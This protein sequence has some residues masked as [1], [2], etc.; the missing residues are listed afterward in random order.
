MLTDKIQIKLTAGHGGAGHVSYFPGRK[1]KP[2]GG[3]GGDGG[4]IYLLAINDITAL[5]QYSGL[6]ELSAPNGQPGGANQKTGKKGTSIE[7]KIPVGTTIT[8]IKTKQTWELSEIN[9]KILICKGGKSGQGNAELKK[10][11]AQPGL[12]G[13]YKNLIFNLKIIADIGLIGLPNAG[14]TSFLNHIT[15]ANAKTASYAFTTLEPNLGALQEKIIADI[16]GLIE[17]AAQ[18]KGLGHKFLKH[19]EKVNLLIHCISSESNNLK[20]DYQTIRQELKNFNPKLLDK[21]EKILLT[22]TDI[23][24]KT[25]IQEKLKILKKLNPQTQTCSI[26]NPDKSYNTTNLH[27]LL[28]H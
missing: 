21:P 22:K 28:S 7:I 4:N 14:K 11:Y 26:Y 1:G 8:D 17:G 2:S 15:A 3:N 12:P 23:L 10:N 20:K 25:Q 5:N 6:H 24:T 13:E 19:I 9:Q 27:E 18:G 16:P